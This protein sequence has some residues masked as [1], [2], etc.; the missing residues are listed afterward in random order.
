MSI[1]EELEEEKYHSKFLEQL[2]SALY[3]KGWEELTIFDAK[4]WHKKHFT[5]KMS[6]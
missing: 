3:G 2:L 6:K 5:N 4:K 1:K